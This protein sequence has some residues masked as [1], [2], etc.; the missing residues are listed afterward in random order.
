MEDAKEK[1]GELWR[2]GGAVIVDRKGAK[3]EIAERRT[4]LAGTFLPTAMRGS[5]RDFLGPAN[6]RMA[7]RKGPANAK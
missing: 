3:V 6:T 2:S 7:F 1:S 4:D 5:L